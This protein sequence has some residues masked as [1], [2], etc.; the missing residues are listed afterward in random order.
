MPNATKT[1]YLYKEES[2]EEVPP[3]PEL[4]KEQKLEVEIKKLKDNLCVVKQK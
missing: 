1:I 4:T 2:M 3:E